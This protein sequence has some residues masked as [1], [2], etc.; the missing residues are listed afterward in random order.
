[1]ASPFLGPERHGPH[2]EPVELR[3]ATRREGHAGAPRPGL[4]S[5]PRAVIPPYTA[6]GMRRQGGRRVATDHLPSIVQLL[7]R[8]SSTRFAPA[9]WPSPPR[10]PDMPDPTHPYDRPSDPAK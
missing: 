8:R 2:L 5:P 3:V 4:S 6:L 1:M 7:R 9:L 10:N